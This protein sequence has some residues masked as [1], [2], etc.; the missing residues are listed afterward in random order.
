[1]TPLFPDLVSNKCD[2]LLIS[3]SI[4]Q[5]TA[6]VMDNHSHRERHTT[7]EEP[8]SFFDVLVVCMRKGGV[9]WWV[10]SAGGGGCGGV[11]GGCWYCFIVLLN[12]LFSHYDAGF[13]TIH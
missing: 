4:E 2:K 12:A 5:K 6:A 9:G 1:M 3:M 7:T 8:H 13:N 11:G 10:S